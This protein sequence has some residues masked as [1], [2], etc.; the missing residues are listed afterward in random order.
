GKTLLHCH[1]GCQT[2]QI[3]RA[4]GLSMGDLFQ[5]KTGGRT[6]VAT[7]DYPDESGTLLFQVLRYAPKDFKVRRPDGKGGWVYSMEGIKRVPYLLSEIVKCK[8]VFVTEGEK[9]AE[10]G[11]CDLDLPTTTAPF[12]AGKWRPEYNPYFAG[13]IVRLIPHND[14]AGQRHMQAVACSLFP[15]A[16]KVKIVELPFGKD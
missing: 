16:D 10:T 9:D 1:A 7:Y 13:T 3:V 15:V 2:E 8:K 12:G 6:L 4:L 5:D 14:E 11:S